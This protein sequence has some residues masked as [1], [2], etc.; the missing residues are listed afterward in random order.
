MLMKNNTVAIAFI[1][2]NG[3]V[4]PTLTAIQ[5]LVSNKQ[6]TTIYKIYV[7]TSELNESNTNYLR[8]LQ[9]KI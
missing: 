5:S 4:I 6:E 1:C 3:Y 2:D 7:V 9:K 8:M